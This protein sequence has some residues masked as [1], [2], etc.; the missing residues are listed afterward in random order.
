MALHDAHVRPAP[1]ISTRCG[2]NYNQNWY[3]QG[4][5]VDPNDAD[6][7]FVDTYDVWRGTR[8]G[9]S[10]TDLTCGYG[11]GETVHV[12][13]H[14]L[15]FV[16]NSSDI[17]LIGSDGGMFATT[18][19]TTASGPANFFNM[20]DGLNTIEFYSGDVSGYFATS[21]NPSAVGGA[22][23]N[24]P[25]AAG[26]PNGGFNGPVQW[27][28]VT[29]GDGFLGRIDPVGSGSTEGQYPRY[30]TTNNGG[31]LSRCVSSASNT[32]LHG[33]GW[34][35]FGGGWSGDARKSFVQPIDIFHG[36]IPGGDDC[37]PAGAT[38]G[39]GHLLDG[40]YRVWETVG[41]ATGTA[42]WYITSPDLT[43]G[44][45]ADRSYINQIKYS[46]K[47]DSQA[48]A[49][50]NDG[51]VWIGFNLGTGAANQANWVNV[52]GR[53]TVLPNRP[54]LGIALDPTTAD[55]TLAIGY[56]AV[57]GFNANT[58]TTPGHLFQVDLHRELRHV[59][60]AEQERRPA[61]HPGRLGHRRTRT[62]RSRSSR[63]LTSASTTPTT[64]TPPRRPGSA[65]TTAC[66]TR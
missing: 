63:E 9:S 8:N 19:A 7:I 39:C 41:G 49:G 32:C 42:N 17:L 37:G 62:T 51:N 53:N 2:G 65:S 64:S 48:I 55:R 52:T 20:D 44:T 36:G 3:D 29:G 11:G 43:K 35:G 15:A 40:T 22:Q 38:T 13:Q 18:Q 5:A 24:G 54:V 6:K 21:T 23:D 61:G 45:L 4:I 50:T 56:A 46:P 25:S 59:H 27:N 12:D 30:Y 26:F 10:I 58:P 31:A 16:H 57:G 66:R 28:L 60:V 34:G 1:W 33:G 47:W 14:A